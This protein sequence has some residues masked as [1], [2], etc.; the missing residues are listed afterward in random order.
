MVLEKHLNDFLKSM[1]SFPEMIIV[2]F[3]IILLIINRFSA[4]KRLK[5]L[6]FIKNCIFLSGSLL[7]LP[8]Y[9]L[10]IMG[11]VFPGK[12]LIDAWKIQ[13]ALTPCAKAKLPPAIILILPP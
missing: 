3:N 6:L 9:F 11:A 4:L 10:K 13:R 7:Y 12:L 1:R 2:F 8:G 5:P